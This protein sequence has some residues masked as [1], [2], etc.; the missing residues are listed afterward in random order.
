MFC[1][2]CRKVPGSDFTGTRMMATGHCFAP[3]VVR[4]EQGDGIAALAPRGA[5]ATADCIE[6]SPSRIGEDASAWHRWYTCLSRF[7]GCEDEQGKIF[8]TSFGREARIGPKCD[9]FRKK[10]DGVCG[11]CKRGFDQDV[12]QAFTRWWGEFRER[13]LK[14]EDDGWKA[15]DKRV[16]EAA[17]SKEDA[18]KRIVAQIRRREEEDEEAL[19]GCSSASSPPPL[20][21]RPSAAASA[22]ARGPHAIKRKIK[23]HIG[24][25]ERLLGDL[26]SDCSDESDYF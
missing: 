13:I 4:A 22:P 11:K 17:Q 5:C 6:D 24:A 14:I 23:Q 25:V 3:G 12:R 10:D 26:V 7:D 8:A 2:E 19:F 16:D 21:R 1:W 18:R 9:R 20:K 15:F